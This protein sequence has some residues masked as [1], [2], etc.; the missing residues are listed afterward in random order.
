MIAFS[1]NASSLTGPASHGF[2]HHAQRHGRPFRNDPCH[3]CRGG[4]HGGLRLASGAMISLADVAAGSLLPLRADRVLAT[5]TR[6]EALSGCPERRAEFAEPFA[7]HCLC[8]DAANHVHRSIYAPTGAAQ[9]PVLS[10]NA[11]AFFTK[12]LIIGFL[13]DQSIGF[14]SNCDFNVAK[15]SFSTIICV[16]GDR[17]M[18]AFIVAYSIGVSLRSCG[19]S[20][21]ARSAASSCC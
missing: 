13:I 9:E 11:A 17:R 1:A 7:S 8:C 14:S 5:G 18:L 16:G 15:W 20:P 12:P 10:Q 3:L 6:R 4:G 21:P 2:A 19:P